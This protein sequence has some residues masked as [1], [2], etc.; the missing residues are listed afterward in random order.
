MKYKIGVI[1]LKG[2]PAYGGAAT[3]G[4]N[5]I[6]QL[7]HVYDFTVYS[8]SSHTDYKNGKLNGFNQ[9]VFK[10]FP[11]KKL[12]TLLYYIRA[13]LHAIFFAKYDLIHLHH[14]DAAFVLLLLKFKYKVIITTHSS[15]FV[16]KKWQTFSWFFKIN[17]RYFVKKAN[18]VTCVSKNE[19]RL[20]QSNINLN[21]NYIPNGVN[22]INVENLPKI[23]DE[24]YLFFGANRI[25][26]SKG[27]DFLLKAIRKIDF[28]G[29]LL[30][31]GDL[32]HT[33]DYKKTILSLSKGLNVKFI[34]LIKQKDLLYSY[35]NNSKI[36]I[37]PST[38]EA[39]SMMLLEGA[40]VQA[41]IICSDIIENR[42]VFNDDHVVFFRSTD[43]NDLAE[44]LKWSLQNP[45]IMSKKAKKA[46]M[47]VKTT[48][49]WNSIGKEYDKLFQDIIKM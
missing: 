5:I 39:M 15:F 37:F 26:D 25:I 19:K 44:K 34:G 17:E 13:T 21:V 6:N 42:D 38:L 10:A 27:L 2:L 46:Y 7:N 33:I 22:D 23:S 11:N 18:I 4:E 14:R 29:T 16:R 24:D 32:E 31:A 49:S 43:I 36:F 12:N 8:I 28:K 20:Y 41:P 1:G 40:S 30:V 35:L 3:V 9:I 48:Y 47:F 45:E